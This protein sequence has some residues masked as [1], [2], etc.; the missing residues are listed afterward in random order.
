MLILTIKLF[1]QKITLSPETS[2][3]QGER[4]FS[5]N[6]VPAFNCAGYAMLC[7]AYPYLLQ[8]IALSN[9]NLPTWGNNV[10]AHLRSDRVSL[11][12]RI[13]RAS[14]ERGIRRFAS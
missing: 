12:R 6:A 3:N 5:G 11:S 4:N 10:A 13:P 9:P 1:A 14:R 2:K 8:T 7:H